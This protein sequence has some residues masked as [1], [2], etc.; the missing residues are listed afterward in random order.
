MK[1]TEI[2]STMNTTWDPEEGEEIQGQLA[3]IRKDVGPNHSNVYV[4]QTED[5]EIDIWGKTVLDQE[6][7]KIP[8][9]TDVRIKYLGDK[10]NPSTGRTFKAF[11]IWK[12]ETE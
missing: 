7:P 6:L 4:I 1:W 5:G 11:Q 9:G 2:T 3:E 10:E 8:I 12:G